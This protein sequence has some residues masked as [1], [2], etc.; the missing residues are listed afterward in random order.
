MIFNLI[1]AGVFFFDHEFVS[2]SLEPWR[3]FF[4][5]VLPSGL[6]TVFLMFSYSLIEG[7]GKLV[8]KWWFLIYLVPFSIFML[9]DLFILGSPEHTDDVLNEPGVIYH[10]FFKSQKVFVVIVSIILWK[11][12]NRYHLSLREQLSDIESYSLNWLRNIILLM[13]LIFMIHFVVFLSLN[14][15]WVPSLSLAHQL[16]N[17]ALMAVVVYFS[18]HG[19]RLYNYVDLKE[20]NE[21]IEEK[22]DNSIK[23]EQRLT[24]ADLIIYTN[25]QETFSTKRLFTDPNLRLKNVADLL[26]IPSHKLSQVINDHY[27]SPFYDFVAEYRINDLKEELIKPENQALS[28]LG[29]ALNSGFN[30]KASLNR[31][32]KAHTGMTPS[33]YQTVNIETK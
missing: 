27:G 31:V 3:V 19:I 10:V 18:Y 16:T 15:G 12:V 1:I 32:F 30:S 24:E 20:V 5:Y 9:L 23:D 22:E 26:E 28:I 2:S 14:A 33:E 11:K 17:V 8:I 25:L 29:M 6:I 21:I 13:A 4:H 7:G